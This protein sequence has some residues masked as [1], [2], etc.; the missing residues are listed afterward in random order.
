MTLPLASRTINLQEICSCGFISSLFWVSVMPFNK[1]C[2]SNNLKKNADHQYWSGYLSSLFFDS[3]ADLEEASNLTRKSAPFKRKVKRLHQDL[4][5]SNSLPP[6]SPWQWP[7][8]C[9]F[10][11]TT[12]DTARQRLTS[13][14]CHA[15]PA[16][17]P[18]LPCWC[19]DTKEH[20]FGSSMCNLNV[21]GTEV[22]R[23]PMWSWEKGAEQTTLKSCNL[24][25]LTPNRQS[26]W[27]DQL[28][29]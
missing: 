16:S 19:W 24:C 21:Q 26:N 3:P 7:T 8:L 13:C 2:Y 27:P 23:D 22:M 20:L 6:V 9:G 1:T 29:L 4:L 11:W 28:V 15:P 25:N 14:Q 18:R 10:P 5:C 12:T 17:C